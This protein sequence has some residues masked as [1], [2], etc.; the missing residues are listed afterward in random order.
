MTAKIY[1]VVN[2][3]GGVAKTTTSVSLAHG[4]ALKLQETGDG[5]VLLID[6][7]PQGNVATSLG[8]DTQGKCISDL[9]LG[10]RALE[11]S[12][13]SADRSQSGGPARPNL[14]IIPATDRLAQTKVEMIA[15]AAVNQVVRQM[16]R[17]KGSDDVPVA[18]VLEQRLA[19]ASQV[20]SYIIIDCPPTLDLLQDSVYRFAHAAIVPVKVDYL[21]AAGA[22][23]H[24]QGILEAQADGIDIKIVMIVPTFVR[25][26]QLLARQMLKTLKETYGEKRV[27]APVPT[28]VKV[29]EAPAASGQ[30]IFEY[31]PDSKPAEAYWNLV[32]RIYN[33]G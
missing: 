26:R 17:R 31:A 5:A 16:T 21:G 4:L 3:K 13:I 25:S 1:A 33:N 14:Y 19:D 32:E 9:L 8:V 27:S 28:S 24:T 20:F 18:E 11:D 29:E 23:Q 15:S 30:T 7:D 2:R 10:N 22:A 12:I 6:L